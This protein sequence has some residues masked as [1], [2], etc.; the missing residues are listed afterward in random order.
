MTKRLLAILSFFGT[1]LLFSFA[2]TS[3]VHA[4]SCFEPVTPVVWSGK[5]TTTVN[6]R[7]KTRNGRCLAEGVPSVLDSL[8]F[9]FTGV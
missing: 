7:D 3:P 9:R 4:G 6:L 8:E 2:M 1:V 5:V